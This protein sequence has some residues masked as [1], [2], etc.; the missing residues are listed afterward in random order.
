M[1]NI[2]RK[3]YMDYI[4]KDYGKERRPFS[5][6]YYDL[7]KDTLDDETRYFFD[8][9]YNYCLSSHIPFYNLIEK[10][11]CDKKTYDMYVKNYLLGKY[12]DILK[13]NKINYIRLNDTDVAD[14]KFKNKFDLVNLSYIV[15][16]L[17]DVKRLLKKEEK[18]KK[19]LNENGKMQT[20]ISFNEL[21]IKDHK[22]ISTRSFNDPNTDRCNCKKEYAYMYKNSQQ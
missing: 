12:D 7:I 20:F 8:E 11:Q 4:F 18:Y 1:H 17:T 21:D 19:L 3:K 13:N 16:D 2:E 22:M 6:K 9:I 15:K 5:K 14:V 10:Q